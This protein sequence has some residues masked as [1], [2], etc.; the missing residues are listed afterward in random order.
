MATVEDK[1]RELGIELS[2]PR[3]RPPENPLISAVRV[4]GLVWLSGHT[5]R[6]RGKVG[7]ELSVEQGYQAAR[8]CAEGLLSSLKAEIGDL[9]RVRRV[10]KLLAMV[11]AT[12][13]F[14]DHPRVANG[15]S[16]V[17]VALWGEAGKHTR[18]AV[19][20]AGLPGGVAVEVEAIVEVE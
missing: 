15:C 16:E 2:P 4:G 5:S 3:P 19:G 8:E 1:L 11:N 13:D 10:V 6:I 17:F 12:E 9:D 7:K 18:S 20:M 14:V